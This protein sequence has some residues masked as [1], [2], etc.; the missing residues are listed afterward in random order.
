MTVNV[1]ERVRPVVDALLGPEPPIRIRT[2]DGSTIGPD[3]SPA[4]IVVRSPRAIRRLVYAP[5]PHGL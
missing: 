3:T 1:A 5:A 2:W 4:T